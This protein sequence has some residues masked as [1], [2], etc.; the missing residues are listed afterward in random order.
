MGGGPM[1]D[2]LTWRGFS[3]F[4][5]NNQP[6]AAENG[7]TSKGVKNG[8]EVVVRGGCKG[9]VRRDEKEWRGGEVRKKRGFQGTVS[10]SVIFLVGLFTSVLTLSVLFVVPSLLSSPSLHRSLQYTSSQS[11][12]KRQAALA[13]W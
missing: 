4:F 10:Y 8:G 6:G 11:A 7:W 9:G 5:L 3:L 2:I 13:S 12:A 1:E